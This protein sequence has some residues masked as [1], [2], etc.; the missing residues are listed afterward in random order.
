MLRHIE[1]HYAETAR[2]AAELQY[3]GLPRYD[4]EPSKC[5]ACLSRVGE[6]QGQNGTVSWRPLGVVL[7]GDAVT[8]VCGKCVRSIDKALRA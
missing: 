8:V 6:V 5:A 7:D 3:S 2:D 4:I 1:I